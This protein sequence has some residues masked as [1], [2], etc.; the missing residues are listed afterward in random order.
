VGADGMPEHALH[1]VLQRGKPQAEA[2]LL[3]VWLWS[4]PN[5]KCCLGCCWLQAF[6]CASNAQTIQNDAEETMSISTY[7]NSAAWYQADFSS[8]WIDK[9][10]FVSCRSLDTACLD[11]KQASERCLVQNCMVFPFALGKE[12]CQ[13]QIAITSG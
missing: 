6:G 5:L 9:R 2:T 7:R 10:G 4:Y 13:K 3:L 12:L 1:G 11:P 8:S